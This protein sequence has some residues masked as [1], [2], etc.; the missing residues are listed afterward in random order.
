MI[1]WPPPNRVVDA[2]YRVDSAA[3]RSG[4]I[5]F[6][7][8]N[9]A[10]NPLTAAIALN[11]LDIKDIRQELPRDT[12]QL[13]ALRAAAAT[14]GTLDQIVRLIDEKHAFVTDEEYR[15]YERSH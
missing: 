7:R 11:G 4:R 8:A 3:A 9:V 2:I 15:R 5:D 12:D 6:I 1:M 10:V 13:K 14:V